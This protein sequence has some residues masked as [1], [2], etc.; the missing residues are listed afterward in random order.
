MVRWRRKGRKVV[1]K[2]VC[3][4]EGDRRVGVWVSA[5]VSCYRLCKGGGSKKGRI[6]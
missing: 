6:V 5:W 2:G 3:V 1:L 4:L